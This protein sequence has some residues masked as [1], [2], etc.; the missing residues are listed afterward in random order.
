[1]G[2][3]SNMSRDK[4]FICTIC[5]KNFEDQVTLDAHKKMDHSPE[6]EAP[7]GVG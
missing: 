7:A 6:A 3:V 4:S 2:T 1:M 5:G